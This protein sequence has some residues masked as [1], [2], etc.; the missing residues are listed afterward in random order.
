[1]K[2]FKEFLV[3][4][5][6]KESDAQ[7]NLRMRKNAKTLKK[8][9]KR[10][11]FKKKRNAVRK[12]PVEKLATAARAVVKREVVPKFSDLKPAMRR[13]KV[14]RKAGIISR[15]TIKLKKVLRKQEPERI[16]KAKAARIKK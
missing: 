2:T 9:A 15:K 13:K 6:E 12:R 4:L 14:D 11:K 3:G 7:Y 10:G 5:T 8:N 16:K 1:M